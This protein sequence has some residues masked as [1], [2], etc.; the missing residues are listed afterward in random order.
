MHKTGW[1]MGWSLL[2][3][4]FSFTALQFDTAAL[5][6]WDGRSWLAFFSS[7]KPT[8]TTLWGAARIALKDRSW[9]EN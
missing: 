1:E 9:W 5:P 7:G 2:C 3:F 4:A 6:G 8:H